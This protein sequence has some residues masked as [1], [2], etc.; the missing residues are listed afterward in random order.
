MLV[1][2]KVTDSIHNGVG[3]ESGGGNGLHLGVL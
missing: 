2:E 1:V 3:L